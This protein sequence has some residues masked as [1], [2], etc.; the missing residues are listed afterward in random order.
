MKNV[1]FALYRQGQVIKVTCS[2]RVYIQFGQ[3]KLRIH[4]L[5]D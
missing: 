4:V 2:P 3:A 1:H 5:Q